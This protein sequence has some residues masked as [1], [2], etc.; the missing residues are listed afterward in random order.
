VGGGR[1]SVFGGVEVWHSLDHSL[2][3]CPIAAE[4]YSYDI[5]RDDERYIYPYKALSHISEDGERGC[6]VIRQGEFG[7]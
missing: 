1:I 6:F 3:L 4:S 2:F 5:R 7:E